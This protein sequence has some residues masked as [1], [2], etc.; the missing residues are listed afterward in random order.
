MRAQLDQRD[1]NRG[2]STLHQGKG[3]FSVCDKVTGS[4]VPPHLS[5]DASPE[6]D[7]WETW[8]QASPEPRVCYPTSAGQLQLPKQS[9]KRLCDLQ[10]D[11]YVFILVHK[12][13]TMHTNDKLEIFS[14]QKQIKQ[15][16]CLRHSSS[17][18]VETRSH[19]TY[20]CLIF[21]LISST[22]GIACSSLD[23]K[24]MIFYNF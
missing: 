19:M 3:T 20:C 16:K 12:L 9:N 7:T 2:L 21:H 11:C 22:M 1:L 6:W 8:F 5:W 14:W 13:N 18:T 17:D 24:C 4:I 10:N 15:Q 23:C